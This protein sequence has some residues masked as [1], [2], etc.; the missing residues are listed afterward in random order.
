MEPEEGVSKPAA[1][2]SR[3]VLPHPLGPTNEINSFLLRLN[4]ISFSEWVSQD[5]V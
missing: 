3:V 2:L 5:V 1:I 4:E